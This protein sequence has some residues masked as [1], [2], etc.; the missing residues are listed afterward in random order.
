MGVHTLISVRAKKP[1]IMLEAPVQGLLMM[2]DPATEACGC[3]PSPASD[4]KVWLQGP[5]EDAGE[6]QPYPPQ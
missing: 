1:C 3:L 4:T 2:L 5:T 6:P